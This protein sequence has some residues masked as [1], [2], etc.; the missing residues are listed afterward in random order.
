MRC[1]LLYLSWHAV[2]F[3]YVQMVWFGLRK[4]FE[5]LE[6]QRHQKWSCNVKDNVGKEQNKTNCRR[7]EVCRSR[8]ASLIL[9]PSKRLTSVECCSAIVWLKKIESGEGTETISRKHKSV[10]TLEHKTFKK[11]AAE[12]LRLIKGSPRLIGD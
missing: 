8:N 7:K 5:F 1:V 12:R 6:D 2:Q 10:F 3:G 4:K 11:T 9:R